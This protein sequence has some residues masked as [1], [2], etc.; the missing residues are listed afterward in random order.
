MG[1]VFRI[2][3]VLVFNFVFLIPSKTQAQYW[4]S[5]NRP[6]MTGTANPDLAPFD[7]LMED[8]LVDNQAP[9]AALAVSWHGKLVYARGF[10][11][12]DVD[13]K[14]PV[15]PQSLFRIASITKPFTATAVMHL[16]ETGKL[17]LDDHAFSLLPFTPKLLPGQEYESRLDAI[18][19]LEL[20]QH[21]GGWDRD[22][23]KFDPMFHPVEIAKSAGMPPP[24]NQE[25]I[26]DYMRGIPLDFDPGTRYAYSNFGYCVLGRVIEKVSGMGYEDYVKQTVLNPLGITDMKQ[27]HTSLS[28]RARGEV[29]Y[30]DR[31]GRK[32]MSL[33]P[34][35]NGRQVTMPYGG[36]CLES[37][38][39]HGAWIASAPDLIR[40]LTA[41][42]D[43][44]HCPLLNPRT[45]AAM[46]ARPPGAAGMTA[47]NTPAPS[48]YGFGWEVR[49][50][51]ATQ[52]GGF[53]AWH[54]GLLTGCCST[55]MVRRSDGTDWAV[56]FNCSH[57][58]DGKALADKI[59]PL[60]H[61]AANAVKRWPT[62]NVIPM[63]TDAH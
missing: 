63:G 36:F 20:L 33:M 60:L 53:N 4:D 31:S 43:V 54:N 12:A 32:V 21:R 18:T 2:T 35:D 52:G 37:M 47:A 10:G 39:S 13:R 42:D 25:A 16:V 19:I 62:G 61:A 55:L 45:A 49:P 44:Q 58:A 29:M 1:A 11:W 56:L 46:F 41:F 5:Q 15:Q 30:Y 34:E 7:K 28:K 14:E 23:S 40:F 9:G 17:K 26:I 50:V 57:A 59:D 8:F 48:Y 6:P 38:D 24:A 3:I 51:P 22:K 27:G